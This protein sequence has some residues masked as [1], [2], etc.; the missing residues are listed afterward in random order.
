VTIGDAISGFIGGR[1]THLFGPEIKLVFDVED[2]LNELLAPPAI[3]PLLA[4]V[5][6]MG[7]AANFFY[8]GNASFTYV[9]PKVE[10]RRCANIGKTAD[11]IFGPSKFTGEG[12][13]IFETLAKERPS[14]AAAAG[15]AASVY[16]HSC[17]LLVA[18][19]SL[20]LAGATAGIELAMRLKYSQ[21]GKSTTEEGYGQTPEF[22]NSL[23][24]TLEPRI[25]KFIQIVEYSA[26]Y[27]D[28]A[29]EYALG[30]KK[31]VITTANLFLEIEEQ[32][33]WTNLLKK[34]ARETIANLLKEV[35]WWTKGT[36]NV[37]AMAISLLAMIALIL[38]ML[39][40][41]VRW[42]ASL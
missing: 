34:P 22:L 14:T 41:M 6:G 2:M 10:V 24:Y 37:I 18:G 16:E 13:T 4:A 33:Y 3:A 7:G 17:Q 32:D 20:I 9:G 23:L 27:A 31:H 8:G 15:I 40:E 42:A 19:L 25:M 26:V 21:Y 29:G 11:S 30:A 1:H 36:F 28:Y 5:S 39:A 38:G 35:N 12:P